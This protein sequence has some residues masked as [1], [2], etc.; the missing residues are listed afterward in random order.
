LEH[1]LV[2]LWENVLDVRPISVKDNFFELG[3]HSLLAVRLFAQIEKL[4]DKKLPIVTLFQHATVEKLAKALLQ[5][6]VKASSSS[7]VEIQPDGSKP[8][9]FFAHGIGGGVLDYADLAGHLGP[10]QPVY[11]LQERG[12]DGVHEPF[13]SFEDMA[14]HHI[15][16]IQTIQPEGPYY[17]GGYSY[18]GTLAFEI[19]RQLQAQGQEVGLLAVI[20]NAPPNLDRQE[21]MW[22]PTFVF[23]FLK[24]LPHW[25]NTFL[26]LDS[27]QRKARFQR[28][29][30]VFNM[31]FARP[32]PSSN[33][34]LSRAN[35]EEILDQDLTEIPEN[36]HKF[37]NAHY[38]ALVSYKPKGY[39]GRVTLFKTQGYSLFGPFD[40]NM[41]WDKVAANGVEIKEIAGVHAEILQEPQVQ[42]LAAQL[43]ASL[44]EAQKV[45][46]P[47]K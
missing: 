34:D 15:K 25:L 1:Q 6:R 33:G 5:M 30:R 37:L 26:Q 2:K 16:E 13:T 31:K 4:F 18:G 28:K 32:S 23:G 20:D 36:Y 24:N 38:Q 47:V 40:P 39:Q 29:A 21:A 8:P 12:F 41:G 44:D 22:K 11:G 42:L 9:F 17:L 46:S 10:D 3:G 14:A 43:R 27:G 7:L 35:I 19:A 45:N